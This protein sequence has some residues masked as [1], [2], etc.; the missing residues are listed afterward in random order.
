MP[1]RL[2]TGSGDSANVTGRHI[3]NILIWQL[4]QLALSP[5]VLQRVFDSMT[6]AILYIKDA[7]A[8]YLLVNETLATRSGLGPSGLL[9]RRGDEVFLATH[10]TSDEMSLSVMRSKVPVV[11]RLRMYTAPSGQR[12]WCLSSM[13]PIVDGDG[14]VI[15]L[16][17]IGRDLPRPDERHD[18]YRR[19]LSFSKYAE[20]HLG[21]KILI[22]T[23]AAHAGISVDALERFTRDVFHLTPK[24]LLI[25]MRI[26]RACSLLETTDWSIT[27]VAIECGYSDHSA[28]SRQ[29]KSATHMTPRTFRDAGEHRREGNGSV[30][31]LGGG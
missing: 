22:A 6:D 19:L 15:G 26:D 25:K 28:F 29:F 5:E 16:I 17:G 12:F 23:A 27:D 3:K 8:R 20:Q 18:G 2:R 1:S 10:P 7:E 11:D 9:G 4:Q 24:Q 31:R 14:V 13:Y 30:D 21:Q